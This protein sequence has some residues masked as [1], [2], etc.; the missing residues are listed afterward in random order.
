M[1]SSLL[2]LL[3]SLLFATHFALLFRFLWPLIYSSTI[4]KFSE[5]CLY[6]CIRLEL[7]LEAH[8]LSLML[9]F[10]AH[11][12]D[13]VSVGISSANLP[14]MELFSRVL[15]QPLFWRQ[16]NKWF[17]IICHPII[18]RGLPSLF[19]MKCWTNRSWQ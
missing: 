13:S 10:T 12:V 9:L 8:R 6:I 19:R 16:H 2:L 3:L 14:K 1:Y 11:T 15:V 5:K 18:I 4:I 7:C 17:V